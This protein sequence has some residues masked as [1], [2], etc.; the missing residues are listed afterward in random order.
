V[1]QKVNAEIVL[2]LGWAPA[3]LMQFAHPLVAAGV[4]AHSTFLTRPDQRPR[5]LRQTLESM[6]ALTFGTEAE[7]GRA[8]RTIN[9]IHDRVN[10]RLP[11][12][13]GVFPAGTEYSAHDPALLRW[14]HATL[15]DV[16]PRAYELYV[17]P[18]TLEERER[19]CEEASGIAPLLGI[20]DDYLPDSTAGL[21]RYLDGMLASGQIAVGG[22]ARALA[23]E[24]L[25]PI[26][27][28][29]IRPLRP[30]LRLPT[31]GLLPPNF[32]AAYGFTWDERRER[33][34]RLSAGLVRS[35][36]RLSPPVLRHWPIA[37]RAAG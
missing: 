34:L 13:V 10:G 20:P 36:V 25:N 16:F 11:E 28:S 23:H 18:L 31:I 2:L 30:L 26:L 19:Y 5:R 33:L 21:R 29:A 8:A 3:I 4:T 37:R 14:V 1:A 17:G 12:A 24:I 35:G 7:A 32:R 9:G 22:Q 6:L 27:P 15:L